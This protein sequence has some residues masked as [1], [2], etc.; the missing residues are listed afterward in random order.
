MTTKA[1]GDG[2]AD[3]PHIGRSTR[4]CAGDHSWVRTSDISVVI[5]ELS[6]PSWSLKRTLN[7][8]CGFLMKRASGLP[9]ELMSARFSSTPPGNPEI[10]SG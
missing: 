9:S 3:S 4:H 2:S 7:L 1:L 8:P 6:L 10:G 5:P